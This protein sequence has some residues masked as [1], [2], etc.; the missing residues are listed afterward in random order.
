MV[1][2]LTKK[3]G[4]EYLTA[5]DESEV[6]W[7]DFVEKL[8]KIEDL[9]EQIGCPLEVLFRA[10]KDGIYAREDNSSFYEYQMQEVRGVATD[11]FIVIS[12]SAPYPECDWTCYYKD[13]KKTWWLKEDRSE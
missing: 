7:F 11:G 3:V 13:Y 9:E 6:N 5:E 2:R 8:G 1:E 4:N 10:L 12:E